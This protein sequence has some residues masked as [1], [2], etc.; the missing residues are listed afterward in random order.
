[1]SEVQHEVL[2][3]SILLEVNRH[4]S[5][6]TPTY[7]VSDWLERFREAG[8]DG[9][10]LWENHATAAPEEEV[11]AL[12]ASPLVRR[13][14]DRDYVLLDLSAWRADGA[15]PATTAH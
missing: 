1:M 10:E 12:A 8:F 6:R 14:E 7:R 2:I 9:V 11:Q 5:G 4:R 13:V 15:G 3:G